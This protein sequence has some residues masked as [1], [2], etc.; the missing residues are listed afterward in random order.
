MLFFVYFLY[1][2]T[3]TPV[4]VYLIH[5]MYFYIYIFIFSISLPLY[6]DDKYLD[7]NQRVLSQVPVAMC[8]YYYK[9][10][11]ICVYIA[12]SWKGARGGKCM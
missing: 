8:Q 5:F 3:F 11:E 1:F 12:S 4:G 9:R 10:Y 2:S 7:D 6:L